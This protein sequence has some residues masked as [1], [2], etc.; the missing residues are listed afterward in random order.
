MQKMHI[1]NTDLY[2]RVSDKKERLPKRIER[3]V[4]EDFI[5]RVMATFREGG[6]LNLK[7]SSKHP[8]GCVIYPK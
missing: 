1:P 6:I 7:A 8:Y 5:K 3:I 2:Y 4:D